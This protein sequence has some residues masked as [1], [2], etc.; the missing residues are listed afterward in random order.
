MGGTATIKE[1]HMDDI[2]TLVGAITRCDCIP[3][4]LL[5]NGKRGKEELV[6]SQ[7][8]LR[9]RR[10]KE[11]GSTKVPKLVRDLRSGADVE[12]EREETGD[13]RGGGG[14]GGAELS[15]RRVTSRVLVGVELGTGLPMVT[16]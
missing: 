15:W 7:V 5:K 11:G 10:N 16:S 6:K 8:K 1:K 2:W 13:G 12:M 4:T 14:G 3:R 9:E